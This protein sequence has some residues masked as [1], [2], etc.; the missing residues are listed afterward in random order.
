MTEKQNLNPFVKSSLIYIIAT[1]IGQGMTFV[2]IIV[3]TRLMPKGDYGDYSTYYAY[4]SILIVFIGANLYVSLNNAYIDKK[5]TIHQFRKSVLTLSLFTMLSMSFLAWV[6]LCLIVKKFSAFIILFA[7]LHSYAFFVVNYRTYSANMENDYKKKQWLL[8]LPNTMQFIGA[9]VLV[10][11]MRDSTYEARIMGSTIG[12][13][14]VAVVCFVEIMKSRGQL[15][16][17]ADWKYALAISLPST[18][19]SISF[20]IMQQ[21]DKVMIT[22]ICGSEDTAVYS[23]IYYL[24]YAII[25]VDQAVAPVRQAWIYKRLNGGDYNEARKLQKWYLVLMA[26]MATGLLAFGELA[27]RL[28][29]PKSYWHFEYILP[30]VLGACMMMVYRFHT[31]VIM[32]YKKNAVLSFCVVVAAAINVALNAV[33]IPRYGAVAA[34]YTTV[35]SYF[36]LFLL[37]MFV[38]DRL[39][40]GVYSKLQFAGFLLWMCALAVTFLIREGIVQKAILMAAILVIVVYTIKRKMEWMELLWEKRKG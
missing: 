12:L 1:I 2:S 9:L 3:F 32:F 29:A 38:S 33:L 40:K 27:I 25:A 16:N 10:L 7:A 31:E 36:V 28:I 11:L 34:C 5:D 37:T 6:V 39:K 22:E 13:L 23:V 15:I 20:M 17:F 14:C 4:V 19:M 26:L 21:C 18:V 8:I 35:L 30:F 24:G